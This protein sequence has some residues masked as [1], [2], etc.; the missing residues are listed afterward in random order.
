[1]GLGGVSP[2]QLYI[3][4]LLVVV[5]PFWQIFKKA[6]YSPLFSLLMLIPL[7]NLFMLYILAFVLSAS[8]QAAPLRVDQEGLW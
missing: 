4:V 6:G 1:M 3:V 2:G 5:V 7:V 8:T